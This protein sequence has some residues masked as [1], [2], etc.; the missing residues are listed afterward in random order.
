MNDIVRIVGPRL[1]LTDYAPYNLPTE[2]SSNISPYHLDLFLSSSSAPHQSFRFPTAAHQHRKRVKGTTALITRISFFPVLVKKVVPLHRTPSDPSKSHWQHRFVH[3]HLDHFT[4][5]LL[6][7]THGE[8][9]IRATLQ[10]RARNLPRAYLVRWRLASQAPRRS[11]VRRCSALARST[12][13]PRA[14]H[15]SRSRTQDTPRALHRHRRV[16][17]HSRLGHLRAST[18]VPSCRASSNPMLVGLGALQH[19]RMVA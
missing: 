7:P 18:R 8:E 19:G 4:L 1:D 9:P 5:P 16:H 6:H 12:L 14:N 11:L 2:S 13:L 3:N 10:S 15:Q 17:Q